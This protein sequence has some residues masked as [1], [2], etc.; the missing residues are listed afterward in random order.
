MFCEE[1]ITKIHLLR[2]YF[3][4]EIFCECILGGVKALEAATIKAKIRVP[5]HTDGPTPE[6]NFM[7]V[8]IDWLTKSSIYNQWRDGD[9]QNGTT[10]FGIISKIIQ[11]I[12]DKGIT[13]ERTGRDIHMKINCL[14][15]QFRAAKDWLNQPGA[16]VACKES[17]RA[18]VKHRCPYYYEL[19]DVI[20]D[21]PNSMLLSPISSI[22]AL[23]ISDADSRKPNGIQDN[24]PIEVDTP[25][26][27]RSTEEVPTLK[28]KQWSSLRSLSSD[29]QRANDLQ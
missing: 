23:E 26:L 25:R 1:K 5:W 14:E 17:I 6:I 18:A 12:K 19:A 15:Q 21:R 3:D 7:A 29:L 11:I 20:S 27:K 24:K 2:I 16:D 8:M 4:L 10:K 22:S 9:K 28:N 13:T